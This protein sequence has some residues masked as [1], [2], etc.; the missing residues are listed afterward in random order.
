[1]NKYTLVALFAALYF[2]G[3][4]FLVTP[5][6]AVTSPGIYYGAFPNDDLSGFEA[7]AG[8]P[9]SLVMLFHSWNEGDFPTSTLENIRNHGSIPI[10]SWQSYDPE[11]NLYSWEN[12]AAGKLDGYITQWARDSKN[13]GHP[14][15]LRF[16]WEMNGFWEPYVSQAASYVPM[17]KHIH[18]IFVQNGATNV[19]W[20]W[21]PNVDSY[22]TIPF[23]PLYPGDDYVDWTCIDGY[24]FGTSQSWSTWTSF[25]SLFGPTY[26]HLLRLAPSKPIMIGE[27]GTSETG[28]SKSDWITD[29]LTVQ[30]PNN[31]PHIKALVWFNINKEDDWRIESSAKSQLAFAQGIASP[32]YASNS[33][34]NVS[35]PIPMLGGFPAPTPRPTAIPPTSTPTPT[36]TLTPSPTPVPTSQAPQNVP[37]PDSQLIHPGFIAGII[38]I[39]LAAIIFFFQKKSGK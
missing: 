20:V 16:N 15:F 22:S 8:K 14:Y 39:S 38:F 19:T 30:L 36:P 32:Y 12:I 18:D 11:N 7:R 6:Q 24:N 25:S 9:V 26:N 34:T 1:M 27:I 35:S 17:W 5:V 37:L 4:N 13:W 23:D 3:I 21:C 29:M 2:I 28:G 33:F 31:F 10:V